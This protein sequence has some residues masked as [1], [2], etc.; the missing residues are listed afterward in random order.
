MCCVNMASKWIRVALTIFKPFIVT[1]GLDWDPQ[2]TIQYFRLIIKVIGRVS[3]PGPVF[4]FLGS[5]PTRIRS[6]SKTHKR[7]QKFL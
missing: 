6:L 1:R 2:E 3:D 4:K 5:V 7:V